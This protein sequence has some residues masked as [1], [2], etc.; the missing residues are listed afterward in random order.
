MADTVIIYNPQ[1]GG[2]SHADDV[3]DRAD[4]SGYAVERSE[5]AGEAV[6]LTQEAIEA[7]YST[8]VAGGGDGT[9]NEVVQGIDRA[10]AFDETSRS[11]SC[12]S[13]R[14]TTSRS[15]S[16]LPISKPRSLPSMTVSGVLSISGWQPIGP[17]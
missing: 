8:I 3:E 6:T 16:A 2:G 10:D 4:L 17:S 12:L 1:S 13:G 7:G 15:R 14:V 9:V 11:A 5:H